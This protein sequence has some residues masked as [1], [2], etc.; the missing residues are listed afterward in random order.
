MKVAEERHI[1]VEKEEVREQVKFDWVQ[2]EELNLV[3]QCETIIVE[4]DG[5]GKSTRLRRD[6]N[7]KLHTVWYEGEYMGEQSVARN[8]LRKVGRSVVKHTA[9]ASEL[10]RHQSSL[11]RT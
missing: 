11:I 9:V 8:E 1:T 10:A 3:G 4:N 7:L 2:P 5:C 6:A